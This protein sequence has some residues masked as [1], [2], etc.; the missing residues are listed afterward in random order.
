VVELRQEVQVTLLAQAHRKETMVA[1]VA[2]QPLI[3]AQVV[4]VVLVLLERLELE[5]H[6]VVVAMERH[7]Q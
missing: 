5:V 6:L 7:H 3:M 1:Q 2:H 4:V